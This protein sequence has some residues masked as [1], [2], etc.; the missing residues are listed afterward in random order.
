MIRFT[1]NQKVILNPGMGWVMHTSIE[2]GYKDH[3]EFDPHPYIQVVALLSSWA[4]IEKEE[5]VFDF[6]DLDDAVEKW[7]SLGKQIHLRISTDPMIYRNEALGVPDYVFDKYQV[8]YQTKVI[9][10]LNAKFPDY[11]HPI[12]LKRVSNFVDQLVSRYHT[13]KHVV[14][15]D[16]RGYGEWGEWHSGYMHGSVEAHVMAL[17]TL[18]QTWDNACKGRIPLAL[19]GSYEWRREQSLSLFSPNSY[20]QFLFFS[21]FDYALSKSKNITFRRD[22][23]GGALKY[24]DYELF[25][26][27]FE[28]HHHHPL[29]T[30]FFIAYDRQ[31]ESID[32]VRGY[33]AEDA[34]EE[35]LSLHPNYMMLMWDSASFFRE[36]QDLIEHGLKRVG[37]RLLPTEVMVDI[38]DDMIKI[39]HTWENHGVGRLYE[40]HECRFIIEYENGSSTTFVDDQ[41]NLHNVTERQPKSHITLIKDTQNQNIVSIH[42]GIFLLNYSQWMNMPV[43]EM[44]KEG[45][46]LLYQNRKAK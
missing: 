24:Y 5:D 7:A 36:R 16:L 31:K 46:V 23:V 13:N 22:G 27:Y 25:Q 10:G 28:H 39:E 9:Y 8:P 26:T 40:T 44:T 4:K 2:K 17:R 29:T 3:N 15:M 32:G 18:I 30:E 37:Y 6:Q 34:L 14:L 38:E 41:V 21:G 12:Y 35:A 43:D 11:L 42:L 45:L 1:D 33:F 20:K 19:S